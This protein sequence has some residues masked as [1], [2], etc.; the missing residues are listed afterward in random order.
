MSLREMLFGPSDD[1]RDPYAGNH[2]AK[3]H[4]SANGKVWIDVNDLKKEPEFQEQVRVLSEI[5]T[6]RG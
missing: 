3:V 5:G 1:S 2:V 4:T 6:S